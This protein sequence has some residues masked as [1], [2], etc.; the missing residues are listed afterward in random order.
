MDLF[1]R[2]GSKIS[3][4]K[5]VHN[6]K[7]NP[8]YMEL[9]V[10]P[11]CGGEGGSSMWIHTGWICYRCQGSGDHRHV[12]ARAYTAEEL[13]KLNAQLEKRRETQ[14][15]K[16][17]AENELRH[18]ELVAQHGEFL[19]L[20]Q[21]YEEKSDLIKSILSQV[22]SSNR[23]SEKQEA[24][25]KQLI[26]Q[27]EEKEAKQRAKGEAPQGRTAVSG[28]V[29]CT[30]VQDSEY[31]QQLKMLVELDNK[32]TVWGTIPSKFLDLCFEKGYTI[33]D[34]SVKGNRIS[35]E[36]EFIRAEGDNTHAFYKRPTKVQLIA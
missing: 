24:F 13:E 12:F 21:K 20:A 6:D 36:A 23:L 22:N 28:L 5:I 7:G 16:R 19:E 30:K 2:D 31:G 25:I 1:K 29:V 17:E 15:K 26:E 34:N 10:C 4:D 33:L 3:E 27:V 32:A 14:R 35:F 8:G 11:R 9:H 18:K